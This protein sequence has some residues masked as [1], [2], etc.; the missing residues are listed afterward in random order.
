MV[1]DLFHYGHMEFLRK[2]LEL[3]TYLIAG[4]VADDVAELSKNWSLIIGP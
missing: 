4:I 3:G 2:A 1:A